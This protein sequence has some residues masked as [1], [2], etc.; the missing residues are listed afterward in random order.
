MKRPVEIMGFRIFKVH[1]P[2]GF[3]FKALKYFQSK[4]NLLETI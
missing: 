3:F 1:Y 2:T 4:W